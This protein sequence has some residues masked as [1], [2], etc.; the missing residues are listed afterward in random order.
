[1]ASEISSGRTF[2]EVLSWHLNN[3][4]RPEG[5]PERAGKL[6]TNKELA[7]TIGVSDRT[8][9]Y[10]RTGKNYPDDIRSLES[11]LFGD[12]LAY[13]Q[14]RQELRTA[15]R[16]FPPHS[17]SPRRPRAAFPIV[18]PARCIGRDVETKSILAALSGKAQ[19]AILVLGS[20]G[21]GKSTLLQR[22]AIDSCSIARFRHRRWLIPLE[23][24]TGSAP[25]RAAIIRAVGLDPSRHSFRQ[26]QSQLARQKSLI[27]LD[28]LETP[29]ERDS[30]A[31]EDCLAELMAVPTVS[32]IVALRGA[33]VPLRPGWTVAPV[34]VEPLDRAASMQLFRS[35]AD[36]IS[37]SD[38]HLV[39]LLDELGGVP[40]AIELVAYRATPYDSLED[41]WD[42]WKDRGTALARLPNAPEGRLTSIDR[43]IDLSLRSPRLHESGLALF[44]LL[45]PLPTGIAILDRTALLGAGGR[46]AARQLLSVGLAHQ[47]RGHLDL[48]PPVRNMVL[49]LHPLDKEETARWRRHFLRLVRE[50]GPRLGWREGAVAAA[51][52]MPETA[53]IEAAFDNAL[54]ASDLT[55]VADAA[56]GYAELLRFTGIG[57]IEPLKR[58]VEAYKAAGKPEAEAQC[59]LAV[60]NVEAHRSQYDSAR[61][62]YECAL[63]I[64]E[65]TG[66]LAGQAKC[67]WRLGDVAISQW[68]HPSAHDLFERGRQLHQ[69]IGDE[70]GSATCIYELGNIA[71]YGDRLNEAKKA[72]EEALLVF[73]RHEDTLHIANCI[74]RLGDVTLGRGDADSAYECYAQALRLFTQVGDPRGEANCMQRQGDI[75]LRRCEFGEAQALYIKAIDIYRVVASAFGQANCLKSLG[76]I[77]HEQDNRDK[78]EKCYEQAL[79]LYASIPNPLGI[80]Q[81]H[82]RL[83]GLRTGKE[84]AAHE[85]SAREA[86]ASIGRNDLI[87]QLPN[88]G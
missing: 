53:N 75:H 8:V 14:Q 60:G 37:D 80:G 36:N 68:D 41:L 54:A 23:T 4:T 29:W 64:F 21:I 24:I 62:F 12:N 56:F 63:R 66:N 74:W 79:V 65:T 3:G 67:A 77:A 10:W 2:P 85:R 45:G 28:N 32:M 30:T 58:L 72:Y 18:P 27:L 78:A 55:D 71:L 16:A 1:M 40:L 6:W 20:A 47:R 15:P 57:G 22:I 50:L 76:D 83:A 73:E 49:R 35:I 61:Q 51:R 13:S 39:P 38:S 46:E 25:L 59:A 86:W 33:D 26:A 48:L 52:L 70:R 88:S 43:S 69:E 87:I 11:A 81:T 84:R 19:A 7:E 5:S 82:H 34:R 44:R 42:E 17:P 31:V 9:R